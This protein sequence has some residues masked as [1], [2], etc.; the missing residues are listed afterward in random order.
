VDET[1]HFWRWWRV[2]AGPTANYLYL[3]AHRIQITL[4]D[5]QYSFLDA[6]ADRSSVSIAELIRRSVDTVYGVV[7]PKTVSYVTHTL[8]RRPGRAIDEEE[9]WLAAIRRRR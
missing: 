1:L 6:E 3:M 4:T 2:A 9:P 5:D 8:G 7:G